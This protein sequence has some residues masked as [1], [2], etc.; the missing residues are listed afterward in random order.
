MPQLYHLPLNKYTRRN[1]TDSIVIH[2]SDTTVL[3]YISM[4]DIRRWHTK[5]RG[6]I[7]TGYH[8]GIARTGQLEVGRPIWAVGAGVEGWNGDS[9]HVCMYGGRAA[10]GGEE[11]NFT[12]AQWVTLRSVLIT[13]REMDEGS[14]VI[15]GHREYPNVHKYCPSFDVKAWLI[16]NGIPQYE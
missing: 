15:K 10:K 5:E 1:K 7:D 3:Q 9:I 11:N 8:L 6:W 4:A 16:A 2:C 12:V 13:L 14:E